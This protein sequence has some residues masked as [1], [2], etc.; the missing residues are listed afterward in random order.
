MYAVIVAVS[1]LTSVI[2]PPLLA[3]MLRHGGEATE[4]EST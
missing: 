4:L 3:A 1:L 2:A